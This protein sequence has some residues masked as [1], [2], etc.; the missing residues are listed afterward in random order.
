[1]RNKN[2]PFLLQPRASHISSLQPAP[3]ATLILA[4]C[5]SSDTRQEDI[6]FSRS[7]RRFSSKLSQSLLTRITKTNTLQLPPLQISAGCMCYRHRRS[8]PLPAGCL[9]PA[10]P[11]CPLW[12][13]V[14][15]HSSARPRE[16]SA[17]WGHP[18]VESQNSDWR[19]KNTL[20]FTLKWGK[21]N[22]QYQIARFAFDSNLFS[23][24]AVCGPWRWACVGACRSGHSSPGGQSPVASCVASP[25]PRS[26]GA[27]ERGGRSG[28]DESARPSAPAWTGT[29]RNQSLC[30]KERW[31]WRR[32]VSRNRGYL[33]Y[34]GVMTKMVGW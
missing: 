9:L 3:P 6:C 10:E 34:V 18:E 26:S 28:T 2:L 16:A 15:P 29:I 32:R 24:P 22:A 14:D 7:I 21:K 11:F 31:R 19:F 4:G 20:L 27:G 1:M 23:P 12:A 17:S 13:T 33:A 8:K 25:P 30:A 5:S